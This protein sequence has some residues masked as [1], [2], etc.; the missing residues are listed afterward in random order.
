MVPLTLSNQQLEQLS[1]AHGS[2]PFNDEQGRLRGYI[3]FIVGADEVA[4]AK[5]ALA[6]NAPGL[7]TAEL[8]AKL[9][10]L[11]SK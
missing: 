5:R 9:E 2:I 7:T 3:T 1:Q 4:E 6:S 10:S 11:D 8:L